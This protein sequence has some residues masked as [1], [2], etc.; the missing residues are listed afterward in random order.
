MGAKYTGGRV[1]GWA[2]TLQTQG[3]EQ[4][5]MGTGSEKHTQP[6]H[7]LASPLIQVRKL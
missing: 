6:T 1:A 4:E 2:Q 7:G 5:M 3:Q